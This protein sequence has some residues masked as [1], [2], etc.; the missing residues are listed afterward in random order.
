MKL[1]CLL[2]GSQNEED[3]KDVL[4]R[5]TNFLYML[6]EWDWHEEELNLRVWVRQIGLIEF[7]MQLLHFCRS[8]TDTYSELAKDMVVKLLKKLSLEEDDG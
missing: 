5:A 4:E 8:R 2:D 6:C 7:V 1:R 3:T